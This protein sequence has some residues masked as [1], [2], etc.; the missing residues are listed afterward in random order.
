[1]DLQLSA[2]WPTLRGMLQEKRLAQLPEGTDSSRVRFSVGDAC[3]L[4]SN[5]APVDAVLAA[6]LLC[7]LSDPHA[8]LERLPSLVRPGGVVVLTTPWSW[9]EGWTRKSA[10]LGGYAFSFL[11]SC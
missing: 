6:N 8:F 9:L 2:A 1:M 11:S 4:P 5:L 7:R 3:K 10:W